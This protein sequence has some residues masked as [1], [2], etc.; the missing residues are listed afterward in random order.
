MYQPLLTPVFWVRPIYMQ[1]LHASSRLRKDTRIETARPS[2][3]LVKI[4]C[5]PKTQGEEPL[6]AT[7]HNKGLLH[8]LGSACH[9]QSLYV[10]VPAHWAPCVCATVKAR[11]AQFDA[12]QDQVTSNGQGLGSRTRAAVDLRPGVEDIPSLVFVPRG[13]KSQ[14]TALLTP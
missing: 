3:G 5:S 7:P 6:N 4:L 10:W 9:A 14:L 1:L 2:N 8:W 12:Q 13:W 11:T